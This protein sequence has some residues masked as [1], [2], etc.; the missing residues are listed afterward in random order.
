[1]AYYDN[2]LQVLQEKVAR[3]KQLSYQ[4]DNLLLTKK[5]LVSKVKQLEAV[6]IKE[7]NDVEKLEQSSLTKLFYNVTGK[8]NE[9][10][11]KE[12]EEAYLASVKYDVA[13]RQLYSVEEDLE[14]K[15]A[16]LERLTTC[17][18]EY[19]SLLSK[20]RESIK[21]S[22][23]ETAS[24]IL[25]IEEKLGDLESRK[26][27]LKEAVYAGQEALNIAQ[28]V[29]KDLDDAEGWSTFDLLGGGLLSDL[30]KHSHLDR[31]QN[32]IGKLQ[33]QLGK[34]RTELADVDIDT[35]W[36]VNVDGFMRFAD[37]FFDGL[38]ADWVVMDKINQSQNHI[39]KTISQIKEVLSNLYTMEDFVSSE[40]DRLQKV[41]DD[42]VVKSNLQ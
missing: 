3:K 28:A 30:A 4:I 19:T 35:T 10:R 24:E 9:I 36:Q 34:F 1:M 16:E 31:A 12:E 42:L 21:T 20:K 29:L 33:I 17:E 32:M 6:K 41:M 27:E 13:S 7:E 5:E 40:F 8:M 18:M 38:V 25:K 15:Q 37:Y 2:E 26:K 22:G 14:R 23:G 39:R 11:E